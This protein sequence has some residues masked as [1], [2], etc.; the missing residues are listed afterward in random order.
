MVT[1]TNERRERERD[2]RGA[3]RLS[4]SWSR[5][6]LKQTA[7][8]AGYHRAQRLSASWSRSPLASQVGLVVL[9]STSAFMHLLSFLGRVP[10]WAPR[11]VTGIVGTS[12]PAN[13]LGGVKNLFGC[14]RAAT[15]GRHEC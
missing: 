2:C 10:I 3:Q 11:G 9:V 1:F 14:Q 13:E 5:S 4:A 6:Q 15:P 8:K 12:Y 7:I